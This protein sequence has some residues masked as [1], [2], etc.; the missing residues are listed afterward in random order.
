METWIAILVTAAVVATGAAAMRS[1]LLADGGAS[2]VAVVLRRELIA[3]IAAVCVAAVWAIVF[4]VQNETTSVPV[5]AASYMLLVPLL[6]GVVY[7]LAS[8]AVVAAWPR[9][10]GP[11]RSAQVQSRV[12]A[13]LVTRADLLIHVAAV[14][15]FVVV[16]AVGAALSRDGL[17]LA[18]GWNEGSGTFAGIVVNSMFPGARITAPLAVALAVVLAAT[19]FGVWLV[20]RRPSLVGA[21]H[22]EDLALRRISIRRTLGLSSASIIAVDGGLIALAGAGVSTAFPDEAVGHAG[23]VVGYAGFALVVAA[24]VVA[25]LAFVRRPRAEVDEG[26]RG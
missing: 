5:P 17:T 1:R 19:W 24:V 11:V 4:A 6:A 22:A 25:V 15:L 7:A 26:S 13:Q 2:H 3:A 21:A 10:S 14:A 18:W 20:V 9:A 23:S 12:L 16:A 8:S